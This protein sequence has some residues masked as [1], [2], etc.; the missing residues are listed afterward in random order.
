MSVGLKTHLEDAQ[1][2]KEQEQADYVQKIVR[3][4]LQL[5]VFAIVVVFYSLHVDN[6]FDKYYNFHNL[7]WTVGCVRSVWPATCCVVSCVI[8]KV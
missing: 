6:V 2:R 3:W 5:M 4:F 7:P 8:F 1:K